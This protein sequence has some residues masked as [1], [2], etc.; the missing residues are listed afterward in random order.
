MIKSTNPDWGFFGTTQRNYNF[1]DEATERLFDATAQMLSK[2]FKLSAPQIVSFLDSKYGR[3]FADEL[4]FHGAKDGI[5]EKD[6]VG[7]VRKYLKKVDAREV[8][9]WVVVECYKQEI[10]K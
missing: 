6:F 7:V 3:H 10:F 1:S 2:Q 8:N 9:D 4:S 5:T